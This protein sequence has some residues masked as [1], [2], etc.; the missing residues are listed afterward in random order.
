MFK[1]NKEFNNK[2]V[3]VTGGTGTFGKAFIKKILDYQFKKIII[4]SRDE[5]KQ[6][7]LQNDQIFSKDKRLRFF[8]GDIRDK[9][10]LKMALR[11]VD[12]VIHAAALKHVPIAEYNPIEFIKTNINGAQNL[13]ETC[14]EMNVKKVLALS[15]DKAVN[16]IN[17]YGAT[18][19]V[20]DKLFIS[21]NNLSPLNGTKFSVVRY[22]NVLDSRGSILETFEKLSKQK[23]DLPLTDKRMTRFFVSIDGATEFV[24]ECLIN[25]DGGEI[26]IKKMK[27]FSIEEMI[28]IKFPQKKIKIT[29]IRPG[30]KLHEYLFV[31]DD[32][33]NILEFR[34][35]YIIFSKVINSNI[36]LNK[37]AKSGKKSILE[38]YNSLDNP[39]FLK[40]SDLKKF[41]DNLE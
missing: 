13:I 14:I 26:F 5:F 41:L 20:S 34:D 31:N 25:M 21:S 24:K 9:E 35:Q 22:G 32:H 18:K 2:T 4:F 15:T 11:E 29:G 23:G 37:N 1:K 12:F 16:P 38:N 8:L 36:K 30:E 28:K 27:S 40:K 17:L 19:L 7:Q 6:F 39:N 10:R 33:K 3:L